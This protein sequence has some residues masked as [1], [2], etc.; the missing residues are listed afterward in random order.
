LTEVEN[1]ERR[2]EEKKE[3]M[4]WKVGDVEKI[5]TLFKKKREEPNLITKW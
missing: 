1:G 5:S 2:E 3:M 4:E